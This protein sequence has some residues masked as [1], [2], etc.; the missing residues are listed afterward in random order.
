[1]EMKKKKRKKKERK[2]TMEGEKPKGTS[3]EVFAIWI[4][5]SAER[6]M[7]CVRLFFFSLFLIRKAR[8][9]ASVLCPMNRDSERWTATFRVSP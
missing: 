7:I 9:R 8:R 6:E 5:I 4:L 2:E 1:M 3:G